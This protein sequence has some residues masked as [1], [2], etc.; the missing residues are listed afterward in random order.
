M[1]RSRSKS[2][3]PL[4]R[5]LKTIENDILEYIYSDPLNP[6]LKILYS[7]HTISVLT[8]LIVAIA[9]LAFFH[10]IDSSTV[11]NSLRY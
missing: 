11:S 8:V 1:G 4:K 5:R 10:S 7:P 6:T 3:S 9:Y 2:T